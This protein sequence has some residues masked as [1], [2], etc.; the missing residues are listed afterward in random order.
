MLGLAEPPGPRRE[1]QE[2]RRLVLEAAQARLEDIRR[3]DPSGFAEVYDDLEQHYK[4]RLAS[5]WWAPAPGGNK[6]RLTP[7]TTPD[8]WISRARFWKWNASAALRL[9]DEG[10]I[11]DEALREMENEMDLSETQLIAALDQQTLDGR[12]YAH[13]VNALSW[14]SAVRPSRSLP[15]NNNPLPLPL[16]TF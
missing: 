12:P 4:H 10:R 13:S 2:A 16:R 6:T 8:I 3:N 5:S 14:Q 1:E 15:Q 9:R 7:S 11:T